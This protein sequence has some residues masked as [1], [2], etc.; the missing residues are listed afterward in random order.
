[1]GV[2]LPI[3]LTSV[4]FLIAPLHSFVCLCTPVSPGLG[5]GLSFYSM[6]V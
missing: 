1:M 6:F 4:L 2:L 3:I 5:Q